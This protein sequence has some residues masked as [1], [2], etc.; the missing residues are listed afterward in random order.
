MDTNDRGIDD[1]NLVIGIDSHGL[2]SP[3]PDAGLGPP[4][5]SGVDRLPVRVTLGQV[6]P[7]SAA[8]KDPENRVDHLAIGKRLEGAS[9]LIRRKESLDPLP[10]VIGELTSMRCHR[11][12]RS[13][14]GSSRKPVC[15][16]RAKLRRGSAIGTA[17]GT[18]TR[19]GGAEDSP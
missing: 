3:I 5:E 14:L 19:T 6:A 18:G 16:P 9:R 12:R 15:Q 1:R 2:E 7:G 11:E 10:L 8:S 17:T 13:R 4:Q